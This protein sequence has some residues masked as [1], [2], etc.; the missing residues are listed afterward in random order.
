MNIGGV[1]KHNIF[2]ISGID[3][4]CDIIKYD[5]LNT[6]MDISTPLMSI[7]TLPSV[8]NMYG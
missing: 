8:D 4:L 6:P 3:I 7:E 1:I 2:S 5:A